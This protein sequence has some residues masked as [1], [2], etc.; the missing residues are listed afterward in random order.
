MP[1]FSSLG[2][3]FAAVVS[4]VVSAAVVMGVVVGVV[5]ACSSSEGS[6]GDAGSTS[7]PSTTAGPPQRSDFDALEPL[8]VAVA[9]NASIGSASLS[10]DAVSRSSPGA[11]LPGY[12]V[13]EGVV[14]VGIPLDA[15]CAW[16]FADGS[17]QF[18][19]GETAGSRCDPRKPPADLSLDGAGRPWAQAALSWVDQVA[20]ANAE[21][22]L[23]L[24]SSRIADGEDGQATDLA[25]ELPGLRFVDESTAAAAVAFD[26]EDGTIAV[27]VLGQSGTCYVIS[28]A[29][30]ANA[31]TRYGTSVSC[32]PAAA[33]SS[34]TLDA[35]PSGD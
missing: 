20:R 10:L 22:T 1:W 12:I 28:R 11:E 29:T 7:G 23:E 9:D 18:G 30:S 35:W 33:R 25:P 16:F 8:V 5:G 31:P 15:T 17:G 2:R 14:V 6:A 34:A 21:Q 27:A 26:N 13:A 32:T 4:R 3:R 19:L 24:A